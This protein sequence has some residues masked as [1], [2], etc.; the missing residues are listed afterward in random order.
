MRQ[1]CSDSRRAPL[2][3][4]SLHFTA[5]VTSVALVPNGFFVTTSVAL[6]CV[7]F[8]TPPSLLR[9]GAPLENSLVLRDG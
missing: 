2:F 3:T 8:M 6:V 4:R 1:G 5:V 9:D 7:Y